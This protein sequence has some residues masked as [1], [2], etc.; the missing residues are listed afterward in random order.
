MKLTE[1]FRLEEFVPKSIYHNYG[2]K[3][4]WFI[5]PRMIQFAQYIRTHFD[6]RVMVNNWHCGGKNHNRGY[7]KPGTSVG[8]SL[9]QHK[10]GRAIDFNVVGYEPAEVVEWICDR[11]EMLCGPKDLITTIEDVEYTPTWVHVDCRWTGMD[12]VLMVKP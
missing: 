7:R 10:F 9:S 4:I 12:E 6:A 11:W 3:A 8:S 5:D 2:E 1:N